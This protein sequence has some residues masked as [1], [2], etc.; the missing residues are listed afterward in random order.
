MPTCTCLCLK[1]TRLFSGL[2]AREKPSAWTDRP[3]ARP[4]SVIFPQSDTLFKFEY[5]KDADDAKKVSVELQTDMEFP[6]AVIF[7]CRPC[8]AK[9][10]TIYD[11]PYIEA[12]GPDPYYKGRREKT[13]IVALELPG[14]FRRLLLHCRGRR[15]GR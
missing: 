14:P 11:R 13:T 1:A 12:N 2:S 7:G 6:N 10:F 5:K 8:D 3:T 4:K 15:T 9:G